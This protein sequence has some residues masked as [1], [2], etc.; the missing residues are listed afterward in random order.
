MGNKQN[1]KNE[2]H[3]LA[4]VKNLILSIDLCQRNKIFTVEL[5]RKVNIRRT[6]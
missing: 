5:I 6:Y 1:I 4:K 3:I 2:I